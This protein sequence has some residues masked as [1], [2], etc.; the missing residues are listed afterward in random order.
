[1]H[2]YTG[3]EFWTEDLS[4]YEQDVY[5]AVHLG[6]EF[7]EG[8]YKVLHKLGNGVFSQVWLARDQCSR[9][10]ECLSDPLKVTSQGGLEC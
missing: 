10:F 7:G 6:D 3:W 2:E 1:M 9:L 4:K 5:Y 8:R